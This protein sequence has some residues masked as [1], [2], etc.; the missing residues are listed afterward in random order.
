MGRRNAKSVVLRLREGLRIA[1][2]GLG[3]RVR[4]SGLGFGVMYVPG[5]R[6][7]VR[8]SAYLG[9]DHPPMKVKETYYV[10]KRDLGIAVACGTMCA[11]LGQDRHPQRE[12]RHRRRREAQDNDQRRLPPSGRTIITGDLVVEIRRV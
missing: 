11:Y 1:V 12:S 7:S 9:Q 3:F 5:Y 6:G 10:S 2:D 8:R 4:G